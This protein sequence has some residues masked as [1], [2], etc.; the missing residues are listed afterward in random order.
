L[1]IMIRHSL[2]RLG[3]SAHAWVALLQKPNA[4]TQGESMAKEVIVY[5]NVG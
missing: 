4:I 2:I 1:G 5:S 3:E